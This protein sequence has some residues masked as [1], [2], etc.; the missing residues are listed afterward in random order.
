MKQEENCEKMAWSYT[1]K[2]EYA[3]GH[4]GEKVILV[5]QFNELSSIQ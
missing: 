5:F 4:E 3:Q 2:I 1:E